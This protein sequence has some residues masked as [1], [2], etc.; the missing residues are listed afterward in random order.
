MKPIDIR[1]E[2]FKSMQD[3]LHGQR[4]AVFDAWQRYGPTTTEHLST[5]VAISLLTIRPRT[6]ELYQIGLLE[7]AGHADGCGIYR[8]R[9][10]EEWEEWRIVETA[11]MT[12][13][14]QQLL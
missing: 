6:T 11:H 8:A 1:N 7:C 3:Q 12:V 5:V 9:T 10:A 2:N 4:K 14:Q 13:R